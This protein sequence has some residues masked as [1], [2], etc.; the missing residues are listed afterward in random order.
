ME[1]IDI[2]AKLFELVLF[3]LLGGLTAFAIILIKNKALEIANKTNNATKEKYIVM[4]SDTISKCV[5]A[6]TQTYVDS[7]KKSGSFTAE[8]Q[9]IA[10]QMSFDAVMAVL[11]D[12]AKKYLANVY[13]DLTAYITQAIEAEVK[14]SK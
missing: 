11:T 8:A 9:K 10:F 12:D 6:T 13:G 3:P 1:W 2:L 4:L 7:L 5:A 14:A